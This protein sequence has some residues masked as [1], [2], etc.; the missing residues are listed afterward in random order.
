MRDQKR[1]GKSKREIEIPGE[2]TRRK[3]ER[4]KRTRGPIYINSTAVAPRQTAP[5]GPVNKEPLQLSALWKPV[6]VHICNVTYVYT[7]T[8]TMYS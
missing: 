1:H 7:R 2:T 4:R 8:R 6:S 3:E 5:V